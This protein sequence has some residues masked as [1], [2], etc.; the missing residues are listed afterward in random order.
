LLKRIYD[1][2][3]VKQNK[4]KLS[5]VKALLQC[6]AQP[7]VS[8]FIFSQTLNMIND[9]PWWNEAELDT[10]GRKGV[11]SFTWVKDSIGDLLKFSRTHHR[12]S[13]FELTGST[14]LRRI[15]YD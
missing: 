14:L 9:L 4:D 13:R 11:R 1:S 8:D 10:W 5:F 7:N 6:F 2:K 3:K 15:L 12:A